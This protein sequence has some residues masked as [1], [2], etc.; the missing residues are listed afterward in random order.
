MFKVEE[1]ILNKTDKCR[2][3]FSC[4]SGKKECLC[5]VEDSFDGIVLFVNPPC[6]SACGY[7]M[8]FGYSYVCNCPIRKE[9]YSKYRQ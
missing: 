5:P 6:S 8:S 9:I 7:M 2:S 1:N 3:D 4:L